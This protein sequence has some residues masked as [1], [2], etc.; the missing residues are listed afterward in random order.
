[1]EDFAE[2]SGATLKSVHIAG[3]AGVGMSALAEL[4]LD[5]GVAVSG[6][7]RLLDS[8]RG[9]PVLDKLARRGARLFRQDGTA[10]AEGLSA[11]VVSTAIESDNPEIQAARRL[12][13]PVR[14]RS[15]VLAEALQGQRLI[16][17]AGTCGKSTTTAMLGVILAGCGLDPTVVNGAAVV[18]WRTGERLGSVRRGT[19]EWCVAEVDESDRSL[20]RFRPEHAIL[21]NASADHF[22]LEETHALFRQFL[23]QVRGEVVED[24]F[25][26]TEPPAFEPL[27]WGSAFDWEGRRYEVPVPG[28]HNALNAWAAVRMALRLGCAPEAVAKALAGFRGVERRLE[29][30]GVRADGVPVV[31]DYAHNTEKLRAAW[32]TL[33]GVS[34]RVLGLW[35][36][37]GYGPLRSMM[38]ALA[39]MFAETCRPRDVLFLLPVYDA[40]GMANRTV[41]SDMLA[42]RLRPRGVNVECVPDH[43]TAIARMG[44]MARCGDVLATLGARD[45]ELAVTARALVRG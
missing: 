29:R 25:A 3:M 43:A 12:G 27:P 18:D 4:L 30:V 28:R 38:D 10:I 42:E 21:T 6:S 33:A 31:D 37:H 9:S 45:P 5:R 24:V 13:V 2:Q 36:P 19:G 34:G 16:A 8:G 11:L 22:G 41:Q 40:G 26:P 32:T 20:L 15:D 35:R 23:G 44:A 14:H 39:D 17:V 7:D 1:M